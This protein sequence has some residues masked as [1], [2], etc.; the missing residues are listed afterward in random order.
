M[1]GVVKPTT[2]IGE[3]IQTYTGIEFYPL[4]PR[5]EDIKIAD[6]AKALSQQCRFSGH[7]RQFYSVAEH[8]VRVSRVLVGYQHKLQGLLHDASEAYLV[9]LPRPIKDHSVMGTAYRDIEANLNCAIAERFGIPPSF[10]PEVIVADNRLL[11]TEARDLMKTPL[12]GKWPDAQPLPERIEPWLPAQAER[13]FLKEYFGL[14]FN[15]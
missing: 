3:A 10:D 12:V 1:V 7:C 14:R 11:V 9:D 8:C 2:R 4:D 13:E 15:Q 5:P 6:I